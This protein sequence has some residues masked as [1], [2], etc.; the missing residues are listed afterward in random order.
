MSVPQPESTGIRPYLALF[1]HPD[2]E[3][4]ACGGLIARNPQDW[5]VAVMTD[6]VTSREKLP[7]QLGYWVVGQ[8]LSHTKQR[9]EHFTKAMGVL[10]VTSFE[11]QGRPDQRLDA[12][13]FLDLAKHVTEIVERIKPEAVYTHFRGDLNRDHRLV[14]EAVHVACRPPKRIAI[15]E[16][17]VPSSTEW[18][19][20]E[21][22][23]PNVFVRL[24]MDGAQLDCKLRAMACYED[25]LR[26]APHPRS[27]RGIRARA[28]YW[29]AV[30]D[31]YYAEPFMLVREVR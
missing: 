20:G 12:M 23:R 8:P 18:G 22:F 24:D 29:G 7:V 10:G 17:E 2:D 1:A 11:A 6:G 16:C 14:C 25:E 31:A 15:Y 26:R 4:L 27:A 13:D 3:V 21:P 28:E 9:M 5:H 30:C 19:I